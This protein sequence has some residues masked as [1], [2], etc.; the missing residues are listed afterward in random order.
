MQKIVEFKPKKL[1]VFFGKAE[2]GKEGFSH[3]EY[4]NYFWSC[5]GGEQYVKEHYPLV[6][7]AYRKS[8]ADAE[9]GMQCGLKDDRDPDML[10]I[11][12]AA[13]PI[14]C[15]ASSSVKEGVGAVEDE[16]TSEGYLHTKQRLPYVSIIANLYEKESEQEIDSYALYAENASAGDELCKNLR[17][18]FEDIQRR[19][20][21]T[22]ISHVDCCYITEE[23]K[24][25]T[26]PAESGTFVCE[27]FAS[28]VKSLKLVN[29]CDKSQQKNNPLIVL[30]GRD[31]YEGETADYK[32][33]E[34][35]EKDNKVPIKFPLQGEIIFSD[36]HYPV[37]YAKGTHTANIE[38]GF[39]DNGTVLYKQS[40]ENCFS[41]DETDE[42]KL[43]FKFPEDWQAKLDI[44]DFKV[45]TTLNL[46]AS[47]YVRYAIGSKTSENLRDIPIEIS[48]SDKNY[49]EYFS[50]EGTHVY[51]PYVSVR[52]GCF[53]KD[54]WLRMGD[55]SRKQICDI[56]VGDSLYSPSGGD[57]KVTGLVSGEE[58]RLAVLE[59][60]EGSR[61]RVSQTHPM[62]TAQGPRQ[63]A[64]IRPGTMLVNEKGDMETVKYAF[65]CEYN[66]I[67]YNVETGGK[68]T[69]LIGNGLR[70]G[71]YE[72]QNAVEAEKK[73]EE[74]EPWKPEVQ[75]LVEEMKR[76]M[77]D[78]FS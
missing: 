59:T 11:R 45:K 70:T 10:P 72:M 4:E 55:G 75:A 56:K 67:T 25:V 49:E 26:E 38:F 48:S 42:H 13:R 68:D 6:Y 19:T 37:G 65:L 23:G 71:G 31:E 39:S 50:T 22:L 66:D 28:V 73:E 20:D 78:T 9:E 63:A 44:S 62:I 36:A 53:A 5:F 15:H 7:Q 24:M 18:S 34:C 43:K 8:K 57:V 27:G 3:Q 58:E 30:Y 60:E 14:S 47:F 21:K 74:P 77:E 16:I 33:P 54:T 51:I 2:D 32:Y 69:V 46:R 17:A 41:V 29:P 1:P 52:W 64:D 61:I 40:I 35:G 76:M 12:V